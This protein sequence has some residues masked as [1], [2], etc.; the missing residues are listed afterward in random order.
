MALELKGNTE[1]KLYF[2]KEGK[3]MAIAGKCKAKDMKQQM[4]ELYKTFKGV[5]N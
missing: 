5:D 3:L 2:D 1:F 4:E